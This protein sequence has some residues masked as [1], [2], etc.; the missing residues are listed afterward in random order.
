MAVDGFDSVETSMYFL[1]KSPKYD[2]EKPYSLRFP[3]GP[4]LAQSNVLREEHTIRVD[5]MRDRDSLTLETSGFEVMPFPSPLSY[6]DFEDSD[7]IAHVFLPALCHKIKAHLLAQHV[8]A[9]D[10]SVS[11]N[12]PP[13]AHDR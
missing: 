9:L 5:S 11:N 6:E 13:R 12:R 4:D 3:P 8:V 10:F 1:D 7:K 2:T